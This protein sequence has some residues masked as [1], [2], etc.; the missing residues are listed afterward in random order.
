[1]FSSDM[2]STDRNSASTTPRSFSADSSFIRV[3]TP[4]PGGRNRRVRD[5]PALVEDEPADVRGQ[6]CGAESDLTRILVSTQH[7]A[8]P[9]E[10]TLHSKG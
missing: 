8:D 3:I 5:R 4:R 2:S 9:S 6:G 1:M 7:A 10:E